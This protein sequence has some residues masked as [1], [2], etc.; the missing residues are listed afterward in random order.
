V[1]R[2]YRGDEAYK[3]SGPPP[4]LLRLLGPLVWLTSLTLL[5]TGT[6]LVLTSSVVLA[7]LLLSQAG[8]WGTAKRTAVPGI[9]LDGALA[10]AVT[11]GVGQLFGTVTA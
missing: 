10:I 2:Y 11:F 1:L 7:L 8:G 5:V 4:L 9:V 6:T 3:T